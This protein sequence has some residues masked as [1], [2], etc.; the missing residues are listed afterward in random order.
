MDVFS[1]KLKSVKRRVIEK[2]N[3]LFDD[4]KEGKFYQDDMDLERQY[5]EALTC[6]ESLIN[7]VAHLDEYLTQF[8]Q[9]TASQSLLA[10]DFLFFYRSYFQYCSFCYFSNRHTSAYN[11]IN[12]HGQL[13]SS[14]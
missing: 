11:S 9:I 2:V 4:E 7:L 8:R 5:A 1:R 3:N 14:P 13:R 10:G 6:E 12:R